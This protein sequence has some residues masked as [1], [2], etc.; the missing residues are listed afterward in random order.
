MFNLEPLI[1]K[2]EQFTIQQAQV[3]ALLEDIKQILKK[4][5]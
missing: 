4:E 5:K 2:I 1:K 3:I